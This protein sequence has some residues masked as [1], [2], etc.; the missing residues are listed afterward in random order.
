MAGI[1][2]TVSNV[3]EEDETSSAASFKGTGYLYIE[4]TATLENSRVAVSFISEYGSG[5][6]L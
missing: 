1:R 3:A 6:L 4:G 2:K 5:Y